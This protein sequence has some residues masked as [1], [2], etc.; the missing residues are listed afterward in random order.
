MC[1]LTS[2][3]RL[4]FLSPGKW[5]AN[6]VKQKSDNLL[7]N[8]NKNLSVNYIVKVAYNTIKNILKLAQRGD[9][10]KNSEKENKNKI[11]S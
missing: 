2:V 10:R 8:Q 3:A 9:N 4:L 1:V 11:I 6:V 7:T 5:T